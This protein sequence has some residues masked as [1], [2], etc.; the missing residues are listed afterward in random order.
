MSAADMHDATS[1]DVSNIN[2]AEILRKIALSVICLEFT[3]AIV[4]QI[5]LIAA[6]HR[7]WTVRIMSGTFIVALIG[8]LSFMWLAGKFQA[9]QETSEPKF[10]AASM[11]FGVVRAACRVF[12]ETQS[13]RAFGSP[14]ERLSLI[15]S[16]VQM[17]VSSL[18][19]FLEK[20]ETDRFWRPGILKIVVAVA[21][22]L[23]QVAF[24]FRAAQFKAGRV[25]GIAILNLHKS[26]IK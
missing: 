21:K 4:A 7:S 12:Y 2:W 13:A 18:E 17:C 1:V 3:V 6:E 24:V 23:S 25:K 15:A 19:S 9:E 26:K 20:E 8:E 22:L 5:F 14:S 11:L 16:V 10:L